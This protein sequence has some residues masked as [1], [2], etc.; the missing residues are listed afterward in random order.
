MSKKNKK[1]KKN[2]KSRK[3]RMKRQAK[4]RATRV[5]PGAWAA[6]EVAPEDLRAGDFIAPLAAIEE[7]VPFLCT[8]DPVNPSVPVA[9]YETLEISCDL[10]RV[11]GVC[12]PFVLVED[13]GG[14]LH[15]IDV[16][17]Y[18]LAR[19]PRAYAKRAWKLVK[20]PVEG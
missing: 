15:T 5:I 20:A 1:N 11:R 12:L 14:R 13:R 2:R 9:R 3:S 6:K 10:V 8:C 18:R 17:R 4:R 7:C 16:R 19:L